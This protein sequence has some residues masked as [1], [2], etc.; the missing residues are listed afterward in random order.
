MQF[1]HFHE[2]M[3]IF[4]LDIQHIKSKQLKDEQFWRQKAHWEIQYF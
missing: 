4:P 3:M 2:K 1:K